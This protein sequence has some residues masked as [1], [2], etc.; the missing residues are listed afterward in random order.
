M[1]VLLGSI[2]D[3]RKLVSEKELD[4]IGNKI[5]N[6]SYRPNNKSLFQIPVAKVFKDKG[7]FVVIPAEAS[8]KYFLLSTEWI[9]YEGKKNK[10]YKIIATKKGVISYINKLY[11]ENK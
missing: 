10:D 5:L 1:A 4:E 2:E 6:I 3:N 7:K 11:L 8:R 9:Y